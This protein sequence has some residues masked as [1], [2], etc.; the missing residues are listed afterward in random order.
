MECGTSGRRNG[1]AQLCAVPDVDTA[2]HIG[3]VL[4]SGF[5]LPETA[6]VLE[7][8][9][10]ANTLADSDCAVEGQT[11]Y[12][13]SLL[14]MAGGRIDSSS[15]VFVWTESVESRRYAD[16]FHTLF[17]A[18]GAGARHALRD[19]RLIGWLRRQQARS[20][21]IV[22]IGEGRLLLEAAGFGKT[23]AGSDLAERAAGGLF[24]S[25]EGGYAGSVNA[26]L[27]NTLAL[28]EQDFGSDFAREAASRVMPRHQQTCITATIR[29]SAAGRVSERIQASA[30]WL[31]ANGE[32]AVTIDDAAQVASMSERNFLRRFKIEMGVTPSDYLL[33]VRIDMCCRLLLETDLPVDKI[34]RRCGLGSGGWLAKLFR[35]HLSTTPTEYRTNERRA[36]A[37]HR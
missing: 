35:K 21:A 30:R 34:A 7:V 4:F 11:R 17:V 25:A 16:G 13:V 22:P 9:Q 20:E 37:G 6:T 31:E 14:S 15:S 3:L 1:A 18:G 36:N 5:S 19:D 26:S 12:G 2:K 10:S 32:R 23:G 27:R 24:R 8:L 33:Y 29:E 28:I